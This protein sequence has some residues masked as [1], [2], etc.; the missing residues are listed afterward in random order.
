[1][2]YTKTTLT[3]LIFLLL[4]LPV[5]THKNGNSPEFSVN[6]ISFI[7]VENQDFDLGFDTKAYLPSNFDPY[8][9]PQ[10]PISVSFIDLED[11]EYELKLLEE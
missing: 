8:A 11:L 10:N 4:S 6:D 9:L 7:E 5:L 3:V 1:M 2:V